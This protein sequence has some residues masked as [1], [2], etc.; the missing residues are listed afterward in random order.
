MQD[1]LLIEQPK[2]RETFTEKLISHWGAESSRGDTKLGSKYL[3]K[4][5]R[6]G[7]YIVRILKETNLT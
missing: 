2:G 5:N 7:I 3:K 1:L 4:F 6:C